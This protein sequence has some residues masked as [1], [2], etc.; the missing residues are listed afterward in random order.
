MG[1]IYASDESSEMMSALSR[2]LS[3]AR[4][5]VNELT[6]GS[7]RIINAIAAYIAER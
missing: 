6:A 2:N 5:T 4:T 7:K 3:I 1:L